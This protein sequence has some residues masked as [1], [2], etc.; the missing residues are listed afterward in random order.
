MKNK[1]RPGGRHLLTDTSEDRSYGFSI[2]KAGQIVRY[3]HQEQKLDMDLALFDGKIMLTAF[4]EDIH[5][6]IIESRS[7]YSSLQALYNLAWKG[8]KKR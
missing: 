6:T 5:V 8:A 3:L 7:L 2:S 1:A 4:D